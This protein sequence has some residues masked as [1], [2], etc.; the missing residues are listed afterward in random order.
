V[1]CGLYN[2]QLLED[3]NAAKRL[4]KQ[5]VKR[6]KVQGVWSVEAIAG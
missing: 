3:D 4:K 1:R 2:A 6:V 5:V